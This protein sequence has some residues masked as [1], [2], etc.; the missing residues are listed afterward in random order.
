VFLPYAVDRLIRPQVKGFAATLVLPAAWVTVEYL[1]HLVLPLGTFFSVAYTQSI[2]L[3]LL[4]IMSVTGLWGVTFLVLWFAS[5]VNY[6]WE[7]CF[8]V[9]QIGRGVAVYVGIL[10]AVV[11][12][13][14]LRLAL[15]PPSDETVQVAVLVTNVDKEVIPE[16]TSE[17]HQRLMDGTLTQSDR[18]ELTQTMEEI[19]N[20][21]LERSRLLARTGSKIITWT[22]YNAHV[23]KD[24]ESAFLDQCRQLAREEEIYLVFPLITIQTDPAMRVSPAKL[25]ENKSVMITPAG[26]I[27]YQYMKVNLLIG[28]EE[29]H[30]IRGPGQIQTID[31]PYGKLASVICLDMDLPS[32]MRQAGQQGVDIV[33]SGAID[34]TQASKGNPLH[35][36]MAS[37]RTIESGFSLARG[38]Y[39]GQSVA[40]DYHGT[41]V[42]RSDY[43]NASDRTLVAH[44]PVKGTPT[45]YSIVGDFFPWLC[46]LGLVGFIAL[47]IVHKL[48]S[49]KAQSA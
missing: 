46:I 1:L 19:N 29:E 34:G 20:D 44:L 36:V 18:Q 12:L 31:T 42:G 37:Y 10:L 4:Q 17:L 23:F 22:E 35:S 25:V 15:F 9:R 32:F 7:G 39:Y 47:I 45:L 5:V 40:V 27:A 30:A 24:A 6:A 38:A 8:D 21:L 2:N 48:A 13:G 43:Y 26:E 16:D 28:W 41:V 3:P 14:G 49:A 33:L 11:F